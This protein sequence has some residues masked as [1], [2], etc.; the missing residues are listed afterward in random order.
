MNRRSTLTVDPRCGCQTLVNREGIVLLMETCPV[1]MGAALDAVT[2][3]LNR[4][5]EVRPE[6]ESGQMPLF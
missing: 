4:D 1:C 5:Q 6:S 2:E 3:A